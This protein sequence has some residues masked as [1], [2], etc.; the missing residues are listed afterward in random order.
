M[1]PKIPTAGRVKFLA[2]RIRAFRCAVVY[3]DGVSKHVRTVRVLSIPAQ[4]PYTQ[5]IRPAG[6][7]YLP[8]PDIDGNW[9]PHPALEAEFWRTPPAA[10]LVHIHFGFEHRSPEQIEQLVETL[11]IPLVVTA[12]DIDN[13]HLA[14]QTEHH[15]RLRTLVGAASAVITLTE[16]AARTLDDAFRARNVT[17]APHPAIVAE[18]PTVRR[19]PVVG[20]FLKSLRSNVVRDPQFYLDLS[21]DVALRVFVHDEPATAQLRAELA[22]KVD[23]VVHGPFD[24][25]ALHREVA[26]LTACVLPYTRGTH[27]GWLEMCRDV[28][29][30]VV[31]PIRAATPTRWTGPRRWRSTAARTG[32]ARLRQPPASSPVALCRIWAIGWI[33]CAGCAPRTPRYTEAFWIVLTPRKVQER[34]CSADDDRDAE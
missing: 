10:D 34:R 12:H 31:C 23:L 22:G 15:Q 27:S 32:P 6:V 14:D 20:V 19:E 30:G 33:N 26:A 18:P 13:P 24:D 8:D 3:I 28:G 7:E 5:A 4:H 29:T 21:R 25:A 2:G 1:A 11:P 16:C 17:V 9:W